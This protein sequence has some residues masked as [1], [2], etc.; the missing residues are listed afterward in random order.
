[1]KRKRTF[2]RGGA[3]LLCAIMCLSLLAGCA[4]QPE[5]ALYIDA[6][7]MGDVI[8]EE[9]AVALSEAPAAEPQVLQAVPAGTAVKKNSKVTIDY[10]N[11]A[12]GYVMVMYTADTNVKLKARVVGAATTYTYNIKPKEWAVFPLAEGSGSYTVSVFSNVSGTKYATELSH[13]ISAELKDEYTAFLYPNQYVD[14]SSAVN[15]L[16]LAAELC[17]DKTA[18]LEKVAVV[19]DYVV[20]NLTYDRIKAATV[21]SG[22]LP[23]LDTVLAAKKGICFDYAAL[24]AGMLRSQNVPC[25]LVVGYAGTAYHAWIDVWTAETGWVN[26][27]IF[28]DGTTWQRMD[29]TFASSSNSSAAIMNY[30]GNGKNYD[31]KYLY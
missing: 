31:A 9:E 15:T 19:Y 16:A 17:K 1:M 4:F 6:H 26:G 11:A 18:P 20:K 24:M 12:D 22:Y 27:V 7:A 21:K 29:P 28:F 14:Y 23:V 13:K 25:R 2:I 8:I 5:E 3:L 10:S 30:I